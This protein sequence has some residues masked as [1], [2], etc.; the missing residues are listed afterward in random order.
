[1]Q[2][3]KNAEEQ[4]NLLSEL[5]AIK[6]NFNLN[7][8]ILNYK[9]TQASSGRKKSPM[10]SKYICISCSRDGKCRHMQPRQ[11]IES[12]TEQI[13]EQQVKF[14]IWKSVEHFEPFLGKIPYNFFWLRSMF[15]ALFLHPCTFAHLSSGYFIYAFASFRH[16]FFLGSPIRCIQLIQTR[17]HIQSDLV[18]I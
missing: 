7:L 17:E 14:P 5:S 18:F 6:Q 9:L 10:K 15:R 11:R 4:K 13:H 12:T 3:Q 8:Q 1:M 2:L 16:C